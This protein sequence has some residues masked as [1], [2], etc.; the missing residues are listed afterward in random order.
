MLWHP[1]PQIKI[2]KHSDLK[3][4]IP[5]QFLLIFRLVQ[6]LPCRKRRVLLEAASKSLKSNQRMRLIWLTC[7]PR[8]NWKMR[9]MWTLISWQVVTSSIMS[10]QG[11]LPDFPGCLLW[12][13]KTHLLVIINMRIM[14]CSSVRN[15]SA[16]TPT[17]RQIQNW[18]RNIPRSAII[19]WKGGSPKQ[20][21][22]IAFS[23][24]R[25]KLYSTKT[26][27]SCRTKVRRYKCSMTIMIGLMMSLLLAPCTD[28]SNSEDKLLGFVED[29]Q[30][31]WCMVASN[32]VCHTIITCTM[33]EFQNTHKCKVSSKEAINR[34]LMVPSQEWRVVILVCTSQCS[35]NVPRKLSTRPNKRISITFSLAEIKAPMVK[36]LKWQSLLLRRLNLLCRPK[37]LSERWPNNRHKQL[38]RYHLLR[39]CQTVFQPPQGQQRDLLVL[40]TESS[41]DVVERGSETIFTSSRERKRYRKSSTSSKMLKETICQSRSAKDLE[42]KSP[43]R[44][45][46]WRKRRR[47]FSSTESS[48]KKTKSSP[49]LSIPWSTG[50][51]VRILNKSFLTLPK[52]GTLVKLKSQL[53]DALYP[54]LRSLKWRLNSS[55]TSSVK[56]SSPSNLSL[57]ISNRTT[58]KMLAM[59]RFEWF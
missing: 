11:D 19:L 40:K 54:I 30:V 39:K 25:D 48:V 16:S 58:S 12:S 22:V 3:C 10:R 33:T 6:N 20:I 26:I 56:A 2:T 17:S 13:T 44:D 46:G 15:F 8:E 27:P 57:T 35:V 47:T 14:I 28:I 37:V 1:K 4:Y 53:S 21:M 51:K 43:H 29:L 55:K 42:T 23:T 45:P 32:P 59:K 52:N 18:S 24:V 38:S 7:L 5:K 31:A 50:F 49:V 36:I 9:M 41:K 34:I